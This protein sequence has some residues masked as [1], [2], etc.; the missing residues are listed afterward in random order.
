MKNGA[1]KIN[2]KA[3]MTDT[4]IEWK[5]IDGQPNYSVSSAGEV[6]NDVT[7][8]VLNPGKTPFGYLRVNLHKSRVTPS[9]NRSP[10]QIFVHRLVALHFIPNP[11]NK[12]CVDHID[13]DKTN[14]KIGNLRWATHQENNMNA[15]M[16]INNTSGVAGVSWYKRHSKWVVQININGKKTN[17]GYFAT[18]EEATE[19]RR[20]AAQEHF[21]DFCHSSEK[22]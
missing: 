6:R 7:N 10:I 20:K 17:L 21:G 13:G 19:V 15:R 12:R 9:K 8:F 14:N 18:I 1:P 11:E 3:K 2:L 16:Q 4:I 5:K 22:N